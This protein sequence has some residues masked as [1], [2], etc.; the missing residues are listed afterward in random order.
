MPDLPYISDAAQ[1]AAAADLVARFGVHAAHEAAVRAD[2]S[3]GV[4]NYVHFCRWRQVA[5]LAEVLAA[6]EVVGTVH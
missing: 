2:R 4:G 5:R 6:D 3:R 1:A